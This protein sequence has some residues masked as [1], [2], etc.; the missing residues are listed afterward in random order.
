MQESVLSAEPEECHVASVAGFA[1]PSSLHD[2]KTTLPT[3]GNASLI[4]IVTTTWELLCLRGG[5]KSV[6]VVSALAPSAPRRDIHPS[7]S[8]RASSTTS[9]LPTSSTTQAL[10]H[11]ASRHHRL[12]LKTSA[13]RFPDA[14]VSEDPLSSKVAFCNM[15]LSTLALLEQ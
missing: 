15:N 11:C 6:F 5:R 12:I 14:S 13:N 10:A 9:L 1:R 4:M 7:C 2:C 8:F 3:V